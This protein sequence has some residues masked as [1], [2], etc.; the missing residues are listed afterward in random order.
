[1]H[2]DNNELREDVDKRIKEMNKSYKNCKNCKNWNIE[3]LGYEEYAKLNIGLCNAA[4]FLGVVIKYDYKEFKIKIK[5]KYKN[6]K[7]FPVDQSDDMARLY[8]KEEHYCSS[9]KEKL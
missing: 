5:D 7:M 9:W 1:M 3:Y 8:T 2:I 4:I 6:I